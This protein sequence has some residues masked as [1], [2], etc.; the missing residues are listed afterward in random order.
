M[1]D[2]RS[3]NGEARTES[4]AEAIDRLARQLGGVEPIGSR[5][6]GQSRTSSLSIG[7]WP[8]SRAPGD[9]PVQPRSARSLI[10]VGPSGE[11]A[12]PPDNT[13]PA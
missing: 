1:T 13:T 11:V 2:E 10:D 7:R 6:P 8:G 4:L 5:Y 12:I 9:S 3:A